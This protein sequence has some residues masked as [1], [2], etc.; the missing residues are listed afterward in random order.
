MNFDRDRNVLSGQLLLAA[1]AAAGVLIFLGSSPLW[2][3]ED[4]W[5]EVSREML[6]FRDFLHPAINGEIYFDKP[7]LSYWL[8]VFFGWISGVL[9]EF[10]VRLPSA[11]AGLAALFG[12][13]RIGKRLYDGRTAN[14]AAWLMLGTYGFLLWSRSGAADMANVAAITLAA[15][16]FLERK[17]DC[18]FF[19]YL[20]F[21]LICAAGALAKGL[22][23]LVMPMVFVA[24]FLRR[25]G[26]WKKHLK[27]S[28]LF[29]FV[30]AM[31]AYLLP[32]YLA[33]AIDAPDFYTRPAHA[34][35]RDAWCCALRE[36]LPLCETL[37]DGTH[38]LTGF[39]LVVR[40]N[41]VRVFKPFDHKSEPFF[42]Y[43]Y[44]LPRAMMPFAPFFILA[45][46]GFAVRRKELSRN[47]KDLLWSAALMF[48][49]FSLSGSRRW[50]YILPLLPPCSLLAAAAL[51]LPEKEGMEKWNRIVLKLY[52][53]ILMTFGSL[54]IL[55]LML[56]P[57][58]ERVLPAAPPLIFFILLPVIGL[59]G[60]LVLFIDEI[61]EG[62]LVS[63]ALD[64]PRAPAAVIAVTTLFM[65]GIFSCLLPSLGPMRQERGFLRSV[66]ASL[67]GEIAPEQVFLWNHEPSA[68][69]SYY[70]D[71]PRPVKV[72]FTAKA[73]ERFLK[74]NSG[75]KVMIVTYSRRHN[76][77]ALRAAANKS[78]ALR[79]ALEPPTY[80]EP[81][82]PFEA[83]NGK[84]WQIWIRKAE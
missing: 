61:G 57:V 45:L 33:S 18:G 50:Y 35:E 71:L 38:N 82:E 49:L 32:F 39:G 3:S 73:L 42:C 55:S 56:Y 48:V 47:T 78:A 29:A 22:P 12:V 31:S 70:L 83:K 19:S 76:M 9:N 59:A 1:A 41:L 84:K 17:D 10:V 4:R 74:E 15:A 43:V 25:E 36:Y 5:A 40:E 52:R 11:L 65:I 66:S 13:W 68:R 75:R 21:Y 16:F 58:W 24:P 7:Q 79:F 81:R 60:M 62:N 14:L 34:A 30:L 64:L 37:P 23:A 28:N 26:E 77:D 6:L 20:V 8:I 27:W 72:G 63:D 53:Y 80:A 2:G 46:V 44:E 69:L 51:A 54:A 67:H